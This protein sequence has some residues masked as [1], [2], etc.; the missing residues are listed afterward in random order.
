MAIIR[1]LEI[2]HGLGETAHRLRLLTGLHVYLIHIGDFRGSLA[3]AEELDAVARTTADVSCMVMS[4]WLRGSSRHFLGDQAAAKRLFRDGFARGGIR[5][6][7]QFGLDYR[8]RALVTFARVLWLGGCPDRAMQIAREAIGEAAQSGKPLNV[9]FSLLY[10]CPVF[11]WCGD[12]SAAQDVLGKLMAHTHWQGLPAFH[13]EG[14]ALKGELLIR[15]GEARDGT[16][17]L[18]PALRTMR[19]NRQNLLMTLAA[20][21]LA[22]GLATIGRLDEALEVIGDAIAEA[23]GGTEALELPELL[24]VRANIL[25]SMPQPDESESEGCLLQSLACARHQSA[26]G[27]ELRTAMTLARLQATQGR[28]E[29]AHQLLSC[30]YARFTEGF[31][32]CDLKAA[33]QLLRELGRATR[34]RAQCVD[35]HDPGFGGPYGNPHAHS[36]S[37]LISN[38]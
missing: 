2:A 15:L 23:P 35:L 19:A 37:H 17:L 31:E 38:D 27:W 36:H 16:A 3:V 26:L 6:A 25:L 30:L 22:E 34:S 4:D 13:A 7:Q 8:V 21:R 33:G 14:L 10:T 9:C 1:G 18:R 29:E 28:C 24:R 5:N 12:L 32:T 11:L 20:C